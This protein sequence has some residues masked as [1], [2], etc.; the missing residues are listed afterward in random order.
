MNTMHSMTPNISY[1]VA[2]A[3]LVVGMVFGIVAKVLF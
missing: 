3:A 1:N 2:I